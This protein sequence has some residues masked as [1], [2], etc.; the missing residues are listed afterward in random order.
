M[1]ERYPGL[2]AAIAEI[3][4]AW[5]RPAPARRIGGVTSPAEL[6]ARLAADNLGLV[7]IAE[8]ARF[9]WPGH[10]IAAVEA[11]G[12]TTA[13]VMYGSPSAPIWPERAI[14]R[15]LV[16]R[17]GFVVAPLDPSFA[18]PGNPAAATAVGRVVALFV[19]PTAGAPMGSRDQVRAID[20]RGLDGD[21]Y[22][23]GAGTF[24][25]PMGYEVT[26][27]DSAAAALV[28][29]ELATA[30]LRRNI[31]TTD[32]DLPSLVGRRFRVGEAV[33]VGRRL[34]EPCRRLEQIV[35]RPLIRPLIH[36]AGLRADIVTS[37]VISV[38]DAV[39]GESAAP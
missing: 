6:H 29:G 24:S 37:G 35:G 9:A 15:D 19:A 27:V 7:P 20:G 25:G 23:A 39:T 5:D 8:P 36:R 12:G 32:I 16:I 13:V 38:G 2:A 34:C 4:R 10:W 21:R 22:A 14:G 3:L 26:L 33:L 30:D 28:D 17:A 1:A 31:L 11:E 18:A